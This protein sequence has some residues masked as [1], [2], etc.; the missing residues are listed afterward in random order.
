MVAHTDRELLPWLLGIANGKPTRSGDFLR[1]LAE[2][3][4]RADVANY[5][6][7]RPALLQ[8]REKYPDYCDPEVTA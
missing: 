2:A 1:C 8:I 3:A 7:V 4:L 6:I 5:P